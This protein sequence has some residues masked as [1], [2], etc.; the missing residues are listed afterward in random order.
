MSN[1]VIISPIKGLTQRKSLGEDVFEHLKSGIVSGKVKPGERLV[2]TRIA[3]TLGISRTP[4]R[5]AIHKLE[6]EGFLRK[7][8]GGGFSVLGL[9]HQD[10][11][12]TFG[13]RSVLEA[14][15]ARL[16]AENHR[17]G[18]LARLEKRIEQYQH[19]LEHGDIKALEVINTRFH[20]LLYT[21]SNSPRL[22]KMINDLKAQIQRFRHIILSQEK[23]AQRSNE[24]HKL[25]VAAI[26]NRDADGVEILVREHILRGKTAVLRQLDP[27]SD[28]NGKE[29]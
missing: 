21:M 5:E 27:V 10:I 15:A 3:D 12:E 16:A 7:L 11:D 19:C 26:R 14:Y 1:N 8:S 23:M 28:E 24:D 22:I 9:T 17:K 20:D 25:M 29:F 18:E 6:R 4:V 2:E 13:I